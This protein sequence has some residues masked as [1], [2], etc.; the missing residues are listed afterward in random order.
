MNWREKGKLFSKLGS[1]PKISQIL[2]VRRA[3]MSQVARGRVSS[4]SFKYNKL[5]KIY[6]LKHLFGYVIPRRKR[7]ILKI[8]IY[9]LHFVTKSSETRVLGI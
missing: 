7:E 3:E 8:Y 5:L 2:V 9:I 4:N 6:F 1:S